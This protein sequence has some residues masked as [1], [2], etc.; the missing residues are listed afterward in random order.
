MAAKRRGRPRKKLSLEDLEEN[1]PESGS[2]FDSEAP[3]ED[4]IHDNFVAEEVMRE[5][6]IPAK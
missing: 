3:E 6:G 2:L 5:L 1:T 4:V